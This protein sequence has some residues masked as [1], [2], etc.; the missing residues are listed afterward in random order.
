MFFLFRDVFHHARHLRLADG[1]RTVAFL[2]IESA[3]MLLHPSRT[4][5]FDIAYEIADVNS[6]A[7]RDQKM[8]V[9]GRAVFKE[10]FELLFSTIPWM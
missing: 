6:L 4:I 9:V 7:H 8:P 2:P 5:A 10:G 1:K 3:V